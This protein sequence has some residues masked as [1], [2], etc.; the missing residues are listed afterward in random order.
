[1]L[2]K[3]GTKILS[4]KHINVEK[5][6]KAPEIDLESRVN[7]LDLSGDIWLAST[8]IG[9]LTSKDQ[10]ASWQGGPV[11][12]SGDY[13]SVATHGATMAAARADGVVLS[14]DAGLTWTPM[15]VPSMLTRLH[16]VA[17]SPDGTVWLGAREGV[18]FTH[19]QGKTWLWIERLPFR[20]VDDL[21][22]DASLG[23]VLASSR[24]SD[25]IYAIDPKTS[26]WK[27]WQT[28]Y[29]IGLVR[30]A[31]KRMVA[32]SLYDGVLVE[33]LAGGVETGQK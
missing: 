23:K 33:P 18:Y 6:V 28:G 4:G 2:V 8:G 14:G 25:Q 1:M 19:D 7:A 30:V 17:F 22:Y 29:R 16:R 11:M 5:K 26:G 27:W 3:T 21:S 31:G 20:D 9:L 15:Q 32:A 24:S 12:G 10:G 13:L